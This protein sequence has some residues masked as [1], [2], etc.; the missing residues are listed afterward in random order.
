MIIR[1]INIYIILLIA[2]SVFLSLSQIIFNYIFQKEPYLYYGSFPIES[3]NLKFSKE[4]PKQAKAVLVLE[5]NILKI[6]LPKESKYFNTILKDL[7][8]FL[9]DTSI[10]LNKIVKPYFIEKKD[11]K[12]PDIY[13]YYLK[14]LGL[15]FFSVIFFGGTLFSVFDKNNLTLFIL[16]YYK[17]FFQRFLIFLSVILS[18]IFIA[19]SFLK[20]INFLYVYFVYAIGAV[21]FRS[22]FNKI[23]I[24]ILSYAVFISAAMFVNDLFIVLMILILMA[25]FNIIYNYMS[26]FYTK[27][28][29]I[30]EENKIERNKRKNFK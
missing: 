5:E 13:N 19:F 8:V 17:N 30:K 28:I 27:T 7:K 23:Y 6:Y 26:I 20:D 1:K 21:F 9:Y 14:I 11:L 15:V 16:H 29:R 22:I 25:M 4:F 2:F 24:D 10:K 3:E 12:A 18:F